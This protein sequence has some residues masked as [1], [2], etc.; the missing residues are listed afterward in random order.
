MEPTLAGPRLHALMV[1]L[2]DELRNHLKLPTIAQPAADTVTDISLHEDFNGSLLDRL[3]AGDFEIAVCARSTIPNEIDFAPL[4]TESF[5]AVVPAG[6]PAAGRRWF[7]WNS[8]GTG[9]LIVTA[10][11]SSTRE[12]GLVQTI[13][14]L[15][16]REPGRSPQSPTPVQRVDRRS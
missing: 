8:L 1:R 6:H 12:Q 11:R 16:L 3:A 9:A 4:F 7:D 14:E 10:K 5:I 2:M 13:I 15:N